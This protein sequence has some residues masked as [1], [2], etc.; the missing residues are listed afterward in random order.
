MLFPM[1]RL[2]LAASAGALLLAS[3]TACSGPGTSRDGTLTFA[4]PTAAT[5]M[6]PDLLPLRQMS[7]YDTPVYDTLTALSH[8][9]T[10]QPRLATAWTSGKDAAGPYLDLTLRAGLKFPDGTPFTSRTVAANIARSQNLPKSTNRAS[11][12]GVQTQTLGDYK[13]RLH[14]ANGVG[15]LPRLFAGPTGMMISDKAIADKEDLSGQAAGIGPFTLKS[16]QPSRVVYAKTPGYWDPKAAAVDTLVIEYLADDAKLNAVRSGAIDV[17]ILPNDMVKPA[18]SAG[19]TVEQSLGAENYTFSINSA[20]KPFDDP[21]VREAVNL[22]LDR[23]RICTGLLHG[24]CEATG[25]IMGAGTT[26]FDPNLG[27]NKFP[28]DPERAKALVAEAGATGAHVDIATVA[29]NKTFEQLATILQQQ[30]EAVGLKASVVPLAPP[31]VVSRFTQAKDIAI[32]FGATGNAFDPS[33]SIERYVLPTGLYN[34]G[35]A[36]VPGVAQLA[37]AAKMETDQTKRT[38]DYREI[39]GMIDSSSFLIPVL[40]P[41]TAYVIAPYVTGWQMPWAP[42]FPDFRGVSG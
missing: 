26:A 1:K 5:T 18:E 23:A 41:K 4:A 7:M 38:E 15:A 35:K 27:L 10:V 33:E 30:L 36:S 6:D 2:F 19:Y 16:V 8:D 22:A 24:N 25:Q 9:E 13:V 14:S 17:T 12:A 11:L 42:S 31:Q 37:A 21:R 29:G 20:I 28:Y 34:P 40:T 32:A 3:V 39:S